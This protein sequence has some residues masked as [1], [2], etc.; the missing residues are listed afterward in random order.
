MQPLTS[1]AKLASFAAAAVLLAAAPAISSDYSHTCISADGRYVMDD[2][3]LLDAAAYK[4]GDTSNQIAYTTR[5][6]K[7]HSLEEGHCIDWKRSKGNKGIGFEAKRYTLTI[8]FTRGGEAHQTELR[9]ALYADGSPASYNCDRRVVTRRI[10]APERDEKGWGVDQQGDEKPAITAWT[11]NGSGME[12]RA[13][14]EM[15]TFLYVRPRPGLEPNGVH[16]GTMLFSGT[17]DGRAYAGTARIFTERCGELSFKVAG[18]IELGGSRVVLRGKA[19]KPGGDCRPAGWSDQ[20]L[21]FD[22]VPGR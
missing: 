1:R 6:E 22:L 3:V 19:P 14:G 16:P 10:G 11:H 12:L 2:G 9:C 13:Q 7:V 5:H 8:A 18:P 15:R 17:S 4:A 21:A 20:T